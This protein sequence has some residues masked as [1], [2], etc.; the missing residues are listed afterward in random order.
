VA[1]QTCIAID[2]VSRE[3]FDPH[4][5]ADRKYRQKG[6]LTAVLSLATAIALNREVSVLQKWAEIP[7]DSIATFKMAPERPP[8]Y[9]W[10]QRRPGIMEARDDNID[11]MGRIAKEY[12]PELNTE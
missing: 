3:F 8:Y 12:I 10:P 4:Y 7:G 11:T 1:F 9:L 2:T 6:I 5:I